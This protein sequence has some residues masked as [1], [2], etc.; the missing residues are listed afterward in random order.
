[1]AIK[2]T[3]TTTNNA[4][5]ASSPKIV[6]VYPGGAS[7]E[8][9][10]CSM[11]V[12]ELG[13]I[14]ILTAVGNLDALE[15]GETSDLATADYIVNTGIP[16]EDV[17]YE[18][19]SR[20]T[21]EN[22]IE[23]AKRLSPLVSDSSFMLIT[24]AYHMRRA[25]ACYIKQGFKNIETYSTDRLSGERKFHAEYMFVPRLDA[26]FRWEILTREING[27]FIYKIKGYV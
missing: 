21:A 14:D 13:E 1:M 3:T 25:E 12:P 5:V 6:T 20:N 26:L 18:T 4:T 11:I 17:D 2:I 9:Q 22:A 8:Y 15:L 24:S 27:Y 19:I 7:T 23:S 10:Q 16:D